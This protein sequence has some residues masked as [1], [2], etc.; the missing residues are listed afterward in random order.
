MDDHGVFA[1]ALMPIRAF[2]TARAAEHT[3]RSKIKAALSKMPEIKAAL[4][5]EGSGVNDR[6]MEELI[7]AN[8]Q[9]RIVLRTYLSS[10]SGYRRHIAMGT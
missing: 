10:A 5:E 9:D 3:A 8:E 1:V 4:A 7:A 2:S 6:H